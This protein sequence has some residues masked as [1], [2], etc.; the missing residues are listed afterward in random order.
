M[1]IVAWR[2]PCVRGIVRRDRGGG[3]CR[4]DSVDILVSGL[5]AGVIAAAVVVPGVAGLAKVPSA[6]FTAMRNA[7]RRRR[8]GLNRRDWRR[9]G[10]RK[11]IGE[12]KRMCG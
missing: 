9:H 4:C 5:R 1:K 6:T 11:R 2:L 12:R 10:M 8:R 7:S 3:G